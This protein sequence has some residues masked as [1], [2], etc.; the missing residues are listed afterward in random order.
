MIWLY[1]F[2]AFGI[3][4]VAGA[5]VMWEFVTSPEDDEDDKYG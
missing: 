4:F 1:L 2:F 5:W 3:G